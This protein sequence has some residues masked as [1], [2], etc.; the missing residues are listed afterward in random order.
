MKEK[1]VIKLKIRGDESVVLGQYDKPTEG[2][3][4]LINNT[5]TFI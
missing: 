1:K 3:Y 5:V 4:Y 2:Q